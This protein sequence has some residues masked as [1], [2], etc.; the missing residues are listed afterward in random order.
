M[1]SDKTLWLAT[2]NRAKLREARAI[3][4][5]FQIRVSQLMTPKLEIQSDDLREIACFAADKLSSKHRGMVAVEDSGLFVRSLDGF[6]G[7]LSS[8]VYE[9]I[10]PDGIL[11]L[12]GS[13]RKRNAYFQA[14]IAVSES[15]RTLR[16][17]SGKIDGKIALS[18][19]GHSG[20]GFDPIFIP[21]GGSRTFGEMSSLEK[22][23]RSHRQRGFRRL[24]EWYLHH[25][26]AVNSR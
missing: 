9:T 14:A 15:G 22:N 13:S 6:P 20:F 24:A 17:F 19:R 11:K 4:G 3:L 23:M 1:P 5:M 26:H 12:L 8:Y 7:P 16:V 18:Q 25:E 2:R 10:G 21:M